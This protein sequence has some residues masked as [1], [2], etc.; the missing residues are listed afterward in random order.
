MLSLTKLLPSTISCAHPPRFIPQLHPR[1]CVTRP[2]NTAHID[3]SPPGALARGTPEM[4]P[5]H[6]GMATWVLTT[7]FGDACGAVEGLDGGWRVVGKRVEGIG[8]RYRDGRVCISTV[9]V[10]AK[11]LITLLH[12]AV[13]SML[14][15]FGLMMSIL[16]EYVHQDLLCVNCY[17]DSRMSDIFQ[18]FVLLYYY[19]IPKGY[20]LGMFPRFGV[21]TGILS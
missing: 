15:I 5:Q 17:T 3:Q 21:T 12:W 10:V 6:Q 18:V 4:V 19:N 1:R 14:G 7:V 13:Y 11:V 16:D 20:T 9:I 8:C 2:Q